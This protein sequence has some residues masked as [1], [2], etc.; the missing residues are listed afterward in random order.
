MAP[1]IPIVNARVPR[2]GITKLRSLKLG[3]VIEAEISP[4]ITARF[5]QW[6]NEIARNVALDWPKRSGRSAAALTA[7]AR[8]RGG[9]RLDQIHGYFLVP[10]PIAANEY[11]TGTRRPVSA[12]ALAI[13]ILDGLY[14]D[15]TPKRLGPNS[16]RSLGTFIYLSRKTG[17]RYIAYRTQEGLKLLYLLV[18]KAKGLKELRKIRNAYDRGLPELYAI[19]TLILQNAIVNI[20]NQQFLDALASINPRLRMTRVPTIIPT[21][22]LHAERITPRY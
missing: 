10:S 12:Q 5:T 15:G 13:P 22:E 19:I 6:M 4:Q 14:P 1:R 20:Y 16:W 21:A 18:D 8:V 11:G 17:H 9:S 2:G 7:S 3:A